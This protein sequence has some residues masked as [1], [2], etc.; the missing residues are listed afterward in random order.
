MLFLSIYYKLPLLNL[1]CYRASL[2][3]NINHIS[4]SDNINHVSFCD[5]INI[6]HV[7]FSDNININHITSLALAQAGSNGAAAVAQ[8]S[9]FRS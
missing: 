2:S 5:N 4:F 7:S 6:N 9:F 3:D 1:S 8:P